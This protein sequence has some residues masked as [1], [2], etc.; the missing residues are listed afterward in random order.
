MY[1][2]GGLD[3]APQSLSQAN[4]GEMPEE[5]EDDGVLTNTIGNQS[6]GKEV[7]SASSV[8]SRRMSLAENWVNQKPRW[9]RQIY[10]LLAKRVLLTIRGQVSYRAAS[11]LASIY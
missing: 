7:Q 1:Y 6:P 5:S 2:L 9:H 8:A 10:A 3:A 11:L 4:E